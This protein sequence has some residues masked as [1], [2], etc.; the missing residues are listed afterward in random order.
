MLSY[1][2]INIFLFEDN[3]APLRCCN[4]IKMRNFDE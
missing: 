3:I 4:P 1:N 2:A